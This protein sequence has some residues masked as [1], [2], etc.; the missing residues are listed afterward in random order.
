MNVMRTT[1]PILARIAWWLLPATL[2]GG[3]ALLFTLSPATLVKV[4]PDDAFYYL[5]IAGNI[6]TGHGSTFD[7]INPTNGYHPLWLLFLVPLAWAMRDSFGLVYLVLAAQAVL[8]LLAVYV[9]RRTYRDRTERDNLPFA[10]LALFSFP[11]L[12]DLWLNA[13]ESALILLLL[14]LL[15]NRLYAW[16]RTTAGGRAGLVLGLLA[17]VI[18]LARLDLGVVV[19]VAALFVS[20]APGPRRSATLGAYLFGAL[21]PVGAYLLFN[22]WHYGH[23]MTV[24]AYVKTASPYLVAGLGYSSPTVWGEVVNTLRIFVESRIY[25]PLL[26][27]IAAGTLALLVLL[28]VAAR[29]RRPDLLPDRPSLALWS[30]AIV[31]FLVVLFMQRVN[32]LFPWYFAPQ[33][34]A[35]ALGGLFVLNRVRV[36]HYP[37]V[38][39]GML[40]LFVAVSVSW[41]LHL[42]RRPENH[43]AN[44]LLLAQWMNANLPRGSIV[45]SWDSGAIGYFSVH[46]VVNLEGLTNSY[47]A[48]EAIRTRGLRQYVLDS[49]IGYLANDLKWAGDFRSSL[50]GWRNG[51]AASL[52]SAVGDPV[53]LRRF[54]T[55]AFYVAPVKRPTQP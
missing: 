23:A 45:G 29:R 37:A 46:P 1:E 8:C 54:E 19:P 14:V 9:L 12:I 24:S 44:R 39:A 4:V 34:I 43:C 7:G 26:A 25:A 20:L 48:I 36:L 2:I 5:E 16:N 22:R 27:L 33:I 3:C 42:D 53:Y 52:D 38:R 30:F 50:G 28:F 32:V 47:A 51:L 18:T 55:A 17:G 11:L 49:G 31:H 40:A 10:L 35:L 13:M 15:M 21:A 41:T 6:A